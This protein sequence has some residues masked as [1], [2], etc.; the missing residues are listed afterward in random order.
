[1][2]KHS[3]SLVPAVGDVSFRPSCLPRLTDRD[4]LVEMVD[5]V[6]EGQ[7]AVKDL[8]QVVA[9]AAMCVQPKADYNLLTTDVI[10]P[11][12]PLV[13]HKKGPK[14]VSTPDF[15]HHMVILKSSSIDS[16]SSGAGE[17]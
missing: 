16:G 9:I 11:L 13:K 1:M 7:F 10:E 15:H 6:L 12:I 8:I 5:P 3:R 17:S 4:K 14:I 2:K